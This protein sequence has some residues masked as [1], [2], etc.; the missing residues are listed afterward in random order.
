MQ[1]ACSKNPYA[2]QKT[3]MQ[4]QNIFL[5]LPTV[6]R[7][8]YM[9]ACNTVVLSGRHRSEIGY[10]EFFSEQQQPAHAPGQHCAQSLHQAAQRQ[11]RRR[12]PALSP[13]ATGSTA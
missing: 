3:D 5:A 8:R 9:Q 1:N 2:G 12:T 13:R 7:L 4:T 6:P 10:T 11:R